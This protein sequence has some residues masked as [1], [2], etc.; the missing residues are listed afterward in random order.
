LNGSVVL[1]TAR[2]KGVDVNAFRQMVSEAVPSVWCNECL[3][4]CGLGEG[5][6]QDFR[7][8]ALEIETIEGRHHFPGNRIFYLGVPPQS[9]GVLVEGLGQVGLHR[10]QGWTRIV[11]EKPFGKD[12]ESARELDALIHRYFSESQIFRIDHYLGKETVQNLLILRFAN[13]IFEHSWNRDRVDNVQV[14]VAEEL[15]IESRARYYDEIGALRDMVQNHLTQVLTLLA[16][17]VPPLFEAEAI[18]DE[19][20]KVLKSVAPLKPQQVIL[21]QYEGYRD[22]PGISKASNTETAVALK[23]EI[24]NWR[25]QGVPFYLRTGKRMGRRAGR[26][27]VVLRCAPVSVFEP[28]SRECNVHP[29][30]LDVSI[31]QDEGFDLHFEVKQPGQP[32]IETQKLHFGYAESFSTLP[33][34]YETL[35]LD[36]MRGDQTLFVRSDFVELSWKLFEPVLKAPP[37]VHSYKPGTLGPPEF[38]RLLEEHGHY[39]FPI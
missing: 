33:D 22:E 25:W 1:G 28:L 10:S 4:Y 5:T 34:A 38:H 17:E 15:G 24:A 14:T 7:R 19:K 35:L 13:P 21:G 9:F 27:V 12:L 20:V 32:T 31:Q 11:V 23:L 18:R 16:M 3:Y 29:N 37:P 39:W 2:T 30:V 36:L 8:L 6:E 26:I